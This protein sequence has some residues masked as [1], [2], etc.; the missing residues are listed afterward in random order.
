MLSQVVSRVVAAAVVVVVVV[1]RLLFLLDNDDGNDP[2]A[3]AS[4]TE[5]WGPGRGWVFLLQHQR[6]QRLVALV[7]DEGQ[8]LAKTG[9]RTGVTRAQWG[10]E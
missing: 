7:N 5:G 9:G 2:A 8:L 3:A 10:S 6:E 1:V 4:P